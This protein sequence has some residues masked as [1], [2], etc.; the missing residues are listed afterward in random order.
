MIGRPFRPWISPF[1]ALVI[2]NAPFALA[3][4]RWVEEVVHRPSLEGNL[5]GYSPNRASE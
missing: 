3:Q 5:L 2:L 1:F 4:G